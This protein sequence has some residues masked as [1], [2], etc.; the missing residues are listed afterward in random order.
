MLVDQLVELGIEFLDLLD[1]LLQ[2]I[3]AL[4]DFA[5]DQDFLLLQAADRLFKALQEL[6]DFPHSW[7]RLFAAVGDANP[8]LGR[9]LLDV[10]PVRRHLERDPERG[11]GAL[12]AGRAVTGIGKI[13]LGG[14]GVANRAARTPP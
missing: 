8:G 2:T 10:E 13:W 5:V 11:R 9:A 1:F 14:A 4:A 6:V 3:L 7:I 12:A